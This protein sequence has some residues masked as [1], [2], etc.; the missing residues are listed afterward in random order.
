MRISRRLILGMLSVVA[1]S[2]GVSTVFGG[3]LLRQRLGQEAENRVRQDLNTAREFYNQRLSAMEAALAYTALGERFSEAVATKDVSYLSARLDDVREKAQ[4]DVLCVTDA[5]GVVIHRAHMPSR[6][7]DSLQDDRLVR[8]ILEGRDA[9]CGTVLIP[10][11]VLE[12]EGTSLAE[13][14]RIRVVPTPKAMPSNVS[15]L[16]RG[17]MLCAAVALRSPDGALV[18]ILR[19]GVL[20]NG[21]YALVDQVRNTVFRDERYHNELVG[22]ATIFQND[23]RISTNVQREDGTRAVG[24]RISAEVY[25]HVLRQGKTWAGP[26]WVVNDWYISAYEP[27][28]DIDRKPVGMLY[29]GVL[30]RRFRA[31]TLRT[32]SVF[33]A[34]TLGGLLLAVGVG[35]RLANSFS[36]PID[37]LASAS[38]ALG[39]G[40]FPQSL[41]VESEDEIGSLTRTFNVMA[42]SVRERDELLKERTRVQLAR[43]ERLASTGRLAAGVAHEINNPLTAVL[44][45]AHMLLRK[46]PGDSQERQDVETI[47]E[48]TMR[49]REIVRGLLDF[50]RQGEPKK[51]LSDL[52]SVIREALNLTQ[53]QALLGQIEI[54]EQLEQDLPHLVIDPDQVQQVAVNVIVNA[55]DAMS[56]GGRLTIRTRSLTEEGKQW[57]DFEV[58]DT[59]CGIPEENLE[60]VFD[61]FFTTK[62]TG[63][64]TGLGL[65]IAYG[66]VTQ[67]GGQ[68]SI[69]SKVGQGTSVTVRLPVTSEEQPSEAEGQDTGGG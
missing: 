19:A 34:V 66:I 69:S 2:G 32:L 18:G 49:C 21:N 10:V 29:V 8:L 47:I 37:K 45:F 5:A 20:V 64:G 43:S 36:R 42:Q 11:E 39:R 1:I 62:P 33:A 23:V 63:Q 53:N 15:E 67:Q 68:I 14:A 13:R 54:V 44:T 9:V 31:V 35:W 7:G 28:Y 26:A 59:G 50:S 12:K 25:D 24:T 38:A 48:A 65:A 16:D 41:P 17:M 61:P 40:E 3:Y 55:I 56:E 22:T 60:R 4:L 52:N 46:A 30:A 51:E 27:I 6:A 57:A 58:S